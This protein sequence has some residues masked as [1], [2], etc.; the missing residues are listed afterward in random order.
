VADVESLP[1]H[2]IPKLHVRA[3]PLVI[4]SGAAALFGLHETARVCVPILL[5]LLLAYALARPVRRLVAWHI[6]RMVAVLVVYAALAAAFALIARG[7]RDQAAGFLDDLPRTM[8]DIEHFV[9]DGRRSDAGTPGF[10][11]RLRHSLDEEQRAAATHAPAGVRRVR[12]VPRQFDVRAYLVRGLRSALN[13]GLGTAI[14]MVLTFL[15]LVAGDLFKRKIVRLAGHRFAR[16]KITVEVLQAIDD[17]IERYLI[18]RLIISLLV[19]GGTAVGLWAIGVDNPLVWGVIAGV[20]NVLPFA[21]PGLAIALITL[22]AF[23]QFRTM[24]LTV[25]A[26]AIASVVAFIEGNVLTPWLAS[27]ACEINTVA[28]FVSVLFWGWL[29]GVWGLLLAV[30]IM[31]AIKAAADRIE[32][33]QAIGEL[34]GE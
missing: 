16:R 25:A 34:L 33:L 6:P 7:V 22:A 5:S 8:I 14:V 20:L 10:I 23:L 11:D 28:V 17:Q 2:N 4:I 21:G 9:E 30:P 18:V 24:E 13:A 27:R 3:G 12:V 26:G 32:P 29:W 15:M 31:V 1:T 19:A